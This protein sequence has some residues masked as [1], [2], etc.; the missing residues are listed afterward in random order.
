MR[1]DRYTMIIWRKRAPRLAASMLL[2]ALLC[3][4]CAG[5]DIL[6][7]EE[8][9]DYDVSG[10]IQAL[11]DSSYHNDHHKFITITQAAEDSAQAN[12][13][14]TVENAAI[15]FC[16]AYSLNPNEE[17]MA[18]LEGIMAQALLSAKYQVADETKVETGYTIEVTVSPITSFSGLTEEF[19]SL[20]SQAQE[21]VDQ[22]ARTAGQGDGN[23]DDDD[24]GSDDW[25]DWDDGEPEPTPEPTPQPTPQVSAS[26]LY[27]NKVL[28]LCQAKAAALEFNQPDAVVVMDIRLTNNGELQLDLNQIDEIDRMVLMF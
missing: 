10:Y 19:T 9:D 22:A 8:Y 5:C 26:E 4:G 15:N 1:G 12:N 7:S 28:D 18:R 14:A 11:L 6:P 24:G 27:V 17:Q 16:N 21:E 25:D 13:T 20:R 3:I 2:A 23:Q